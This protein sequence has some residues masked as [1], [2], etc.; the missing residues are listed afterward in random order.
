MTFNE[1]IRRQA[2][3]DVKP[4]EHDGG[5]ISG[6]LTATSLSP[7][8]I[9][10]LEPGL[11]VI[12][13]ADDTPS[14]QRRLAKFKCDGVDDHVEIQEAVDSLPSF[15]GLVVLLA[16][17]YKWGEGSTV[18]LSDNTW[19]RGQGATTICSTVS[20]RTTA[21]TWFDIT[22]DD[23]VI[24]DLKIDGLDV[25][26]SISDSGIE[27][28]NVSHRIVIERVEI[29]R[30]PTAVV[31]K[32]A[33]EIVHTLSD[34]S[35]VHIDDC[36]IHDTD[37]GI[38]DSNGLGGQEGHRI[39]RNKMV[40][41][42]GGSN[43]NGITLKNATDFVI[44]ENLID[45]PEGLGIFLQVGSVRGVIAHNHILNCDDTGITDSGIGNVVIGNV[46][47]N[48]L[49][50]I[51]VGDKSTVENNLVLESLGWGIRMG[52]AS[53][54]NVIVGNLV[55]GGSQTTDDTDDGILV[56]GDRNNVQG[57][58]VRHGGGAKQHKNGINVS[59]A[60]AADN[61]VANNDLLNSGRTASFADTGT[62]TR[63]AAVGDVVYTENAEASVS[64]ASTS[65]ITIA[66]TDVTGVVAGDLLVATSW[67]RLFNDSGGTRTYTIT[68]EMGSV[69]QAANFAIIG[70]DHA[71]FKHEWI[72]A[73]VS[74]SDAQF[75]AQIEYDLN[76]IANN[77]ASTTDRVAYKTSTSDLT[78]TVTVAF[79]VRSNSTSTP[80]T[81]YNHGF[82]VR[83]P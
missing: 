68:L 15:G 81:V 9:I 5:D 12:V 63:I 13:A 18:S 47:R 77:Y 38:G 20:P 29:T 78:G 36:F 54:D 8:A 71:I 76:A 34:V 58:T 79:K 44:S 4:H 82:V 41:I 6:E 28:L 55:S 37:G 49:N 45:N 32:G 30:L 83:K 11:G 16:G 42:R 59:G 60:G 65:D 27:I 74:T 52:S 2:K 75:Q 3:G 31:A 67:I 26:A 39:R 17:T 50:G 19:L 14:D 62:D 25:T 64:V 1:S 66:T 10:G 35:D 53:D 7:R 40:N 24:S 61:L 22:G 57:N 73:V 21:T 23:I 48:C 33:I 51:E 72:L 70:N 46:V 69:T 80:Q 43:A 56:E